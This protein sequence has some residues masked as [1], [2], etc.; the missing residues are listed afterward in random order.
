MI[1][2]T[3]V[4][5]LTY[6]EDMEHWESWD[7]KKEYLNRTSRSRER[8]AD[9]IRA[10]E[11]VEFRRCRSRSRGRSIDNV[12]HISRDRSR[13]RCEKYENER[14]KKEQVK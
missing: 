4:R 11:H 10:L 3:K 8:E 13:N 1:R 6:E 14:R 7:K 2:S 9:K 5:W 12:R